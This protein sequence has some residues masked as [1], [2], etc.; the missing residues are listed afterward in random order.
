[1]KY[2]LQYCIVLHHRHPTSEFTFS[3]GWEKNRKT[4]GVLSHCSGRRNFGTTP[5]TLKMDV[6]AWPARP[7]TG[8]CLATISRTSVFKYITRSKHQ[9]DR[10]R[11]K[12]LEPTTKKEA[13]EAISTEVV[14]LRRPPCGAWP[15]TSR[16][17]SSSKHAGL[18]RGG[19]GTFFCAPPSDRGG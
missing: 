1:M 10:G 3:A 19:G 2:R 15:S 5:S 7:R 9:G 8:R 4:P 13:D 12:P 14:V 17:D 6:G 18:F 16:A 11:S